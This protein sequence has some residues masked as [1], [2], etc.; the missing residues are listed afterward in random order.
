MIWQLH[1]M[2]YEMVRGD[3]GVLEDEAREHIKYLITETRK[4]LNEE[5]A[6]SPL[7]KPSIENCLNLEKIASCVYL[8]L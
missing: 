5:C 6:E 3:K 2:N 7:S 1:S 4:K 8:Y